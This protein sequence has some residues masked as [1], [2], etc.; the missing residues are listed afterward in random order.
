MRFMLGKRTDYYPIGEPFPISYRP[1]PLFEIP[2][3]FPEFPLFFF[4]TGLDTCY[5][6]LIRLTVFRKSR[7]GKDAAER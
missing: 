6:N 7:Y 3:M 4:G 1:E 2:V 5:F